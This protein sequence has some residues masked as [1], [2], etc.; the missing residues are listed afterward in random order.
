MENPEISVLLP[1]QEDRDHGVECVRMWVEGQT[2][3]RERYEIVI[4]A[5]G[6]DPELETAVRE[7]L[8]AR[9]VFVE[10]RTTNEPEL[11]NAAARA[12]SGRY[13]FFTEAHCV[14][15]PDCLEQM[16][17][18]LG[19]TEAV[20]AR[21]RSLGFA[22]G[23]FGEL[24]RI[25]YEGDMAPCETPDH[26]LKV[27]IHSL[28]IRR[29]AYLDTGGFRP[30]YTDFGEWALQMHLLE[31]GHRIE[32]APGPAVR[33]AYT[34]ELD[35]VDFHVRDFVHGELRFL[36]E[37]PTPLWEPYVTHPR[38]LREAEALTRRGARDVVRAG[39]AAA[40]GGI[41]RR[42]ALRAVL[43]AL[44]W[45]LA[46]RGGPLAAM[47]AVTA[48]GRARVRLLRDPERQLRAYRR[49]W[50][51]CAHA[52]RLEWLAQNTGEDGLAQW[53]P[54]AGL[55]V[56]LTDLG[57][58]GLLGFHPPEESGQGERHRWTE[59]FALIW[60]GSPAP[61]GRARLE[62][63]PL[64]TEHE[65][66]ATRVVVPGSPAR[67]PQITGPDLLEF[68]LPAGARWLGLASARK[69]LPPGAA[70]DPRPL[71]LPVRRLRL[72]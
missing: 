22:E 3:A 1:M 13:L 9:D 41:A 54:E 15:E 32:F 57:R 62:L 38:E 6:V 33:H 36:T 10:H 47:R 7:V 40:R 48:A 31:R 45:A 53:A 71:G 16:L 63:A 52:G 37:E 42:A 50:S 56:D 29:D 60:L 68:D 72:A 2:L 67:R 24:E 66:Q 35:V 18:H 64:R 12:S 46:G 70:P 8:G 51:D 20:G 58:S 44:P 4:A 26:W 65:L 39:V 28:A 69:R 23:R 43:R 34:G 11:F 21:G 30:R 5:P 49:W 14:P 55:D 25:V 19:A 59:P 17:D 27:L 61:G